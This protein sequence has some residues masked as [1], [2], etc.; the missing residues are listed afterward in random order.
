M[1]TSKVESIKCFFWSKTKERFIFFR[2]NIGKQHTFLHP[3]VIFLVHDIPL[4]NAMT[5]R[6]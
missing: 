6:I 2:R 4:T 3:I 5:N 1:L